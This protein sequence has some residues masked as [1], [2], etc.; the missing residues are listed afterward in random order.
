MIQRDEV[1]YALPDIR[2]SRMIQREFF[3]ANQSSLDANSV[4]PVH[5]EKATDTHEIRSP[6]EVIHNPKYLRG[7]VER[8]DMHIHRPASNFGPHTSL[9][10]PAFAKLKYRLERLDDPETWEPGLEPNFELLGN[11]QALI[12]SSCNIFDNDDARRRDLVLNPFFDAVFQDVGVFRKS[13]EDGSAKPDAVWGIPPRVIRE[14]Q[15]EDG[16][17]GNSTVQGG[18]SYRKI[19]SQKSVSAGYMSRPEP[20]DRGSL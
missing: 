19:I 4:S 15:N 11:C 12:L 2:Q 9:F 5:L 14:D 7:C 13:I 10:N 16:A 6:S 18:I 8:G 17:G 20:G 3:Q 1:L